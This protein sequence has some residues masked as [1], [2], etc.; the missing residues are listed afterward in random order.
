MTSPSAMARRRSGRHLMVVLRAMVVTSCPDGG[1]E[2][3]GVLAG[4]RMTDPSAV[5]A[6]HAAYVVAAAASGVMV[7]PWI[8]V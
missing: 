8:S 2:Q 4:R 3:F 1:L 5:A 6:V 7:L